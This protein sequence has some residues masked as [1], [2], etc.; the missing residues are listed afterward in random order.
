MHGDSFEHGQPVLPLLRAFHYPQVQVA[1]RCNPKGIVSSSP[2]LR[3]CGLPWVCVGVA[4]Q[5]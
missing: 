5:P 4:F 1:N 2:G 3:A